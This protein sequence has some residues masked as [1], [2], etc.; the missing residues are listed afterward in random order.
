MA[1][2]CVR[3]L[4]K[5][6]G[7]K[8]SLSSHC[9]MSLKVIVKTEMLLCILITEWVSSQRNSFSLVNLTMLFVVMLA[10][11]SKTLYNYFQRLIITP[12]HYKTDFNVCVS[13]ELLSDL[14]S[15]SHRTIIFAISVIFSSV[16]APLSSYW[17]PLN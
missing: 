14:D 6:M 8:T 11:S 17:R 10:I 4:L 16:L 9:L 2:C 12:Y 5:G 3:W 15:P 7:R 13:V 1:D